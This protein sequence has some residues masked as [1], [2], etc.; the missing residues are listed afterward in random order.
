MNTQMDHIRRRFP[1]KSETL[2]LLMAEDPE[3]RAICEDY[4]DCVHACRYWAQSK[5][6]DA[7]IRVKEYRTLIKELENEIIEALDSN[8]ARGRAEL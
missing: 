3:F 6:P 4:D 8:G 7:E 5:D 1:E 2:A